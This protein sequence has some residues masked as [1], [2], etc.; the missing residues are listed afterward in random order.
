M[1]TDLFLQMP[2]HYIRRAQQVSSAYFTE[3]LADS[4]LTSVQMVAL[5]AI[6]DSP[7]I[8]A[9][10]L[11]E[12]I[13]FDRATIGG[14]VDRLER[15]GLIQRVVNPEDKRSK[16]MR[17]TPAGKALLDVSLPRVQRVQ[18]RILAPLSP[19]DRETFLRLIKT[20]IGRQ[21]D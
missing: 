17:A 9:T 11:S 10:R 20:V 5:V 7:G 19:E 6:V 14:V 21:T 13:D 18:E 16:V 3:E 2:G 8:D 1:L 15:K 4:E 12:I